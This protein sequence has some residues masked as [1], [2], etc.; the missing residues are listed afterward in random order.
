MSEAGPSQDSAFCFCGAQKKCPDILEDFGSAGL[1][2]AFW[3]VM[4]NGGCIDSV[5]NSRKNMH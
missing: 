2:L 1:M 5:S 4:A 3:Q